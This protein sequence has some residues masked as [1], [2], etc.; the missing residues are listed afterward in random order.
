MKSWFFVCLGPAVL[1][2]RAEAQEAK[3][4]VSQEARVKIEADVEKCRSRQ[5]N[6]HRAA[7]QCINEAVQRVLISVDYPYMDLLQIVSAYRIAC[8]QKM[9]AREL[10]E[11][12]CNKRMGNLRARITSEETRRR[13]ADAKTG[14]GVRPASGPKPTNYVT[15]L[16]DLADWSNDVPDDPGKP[17]QIRCFQSG[18]MISCR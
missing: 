15:L 1:A 16:K 18:P 2:G 9:D 17:S 8:A 10:T 7:A 12:D 11:D 14:T 5:F 4:A 13:G 3:D 6:T